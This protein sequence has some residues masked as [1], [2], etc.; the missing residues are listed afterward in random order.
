MRPINTLIVEDNPSHVLMLQNAVKKSKWVRISTRSVATLADAEMFLRR[1]GYDAILADLGLPDSQGKETFSRLNHAAP[2]IP[3]IVL[4]I[5]DDEGL[6]L[7]L[8]KEG[9]Q[10]YIVKGEFAPT[11]IA[12]AIAHAVERKALFNEQRRLLEELKAAGDNIRALSE[13]IPMCSYC[14]KIRDDKGNWKQVEDYLTKHYD[15]RFTHG[16]CEKCA[17]KLSPNLRPPKR[18]RPLDP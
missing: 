1:G 11:L 12:R 2:D 7:Q 17:R 14:R 16:I 10:D 13:L 9:A 18:K 3:I 5:L 8:V 15:L 4:T 6:A